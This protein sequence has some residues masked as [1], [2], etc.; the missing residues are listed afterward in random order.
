MK[1]LQNLRTKN[2]FTVLMITL[3]FYGLINTPSLRIF[4]Q[5]PGVIVRIYSDTTWM[6]SDGPYVLTGPLLVE[7]GVTLTVEAGSSID[8]NY[9]EMR[10]DGTLL[11]KGSSNNPVSIFNGTINYSEL[12]SGWNQNTNH[13]CIIENAVYDGV[14]VNSAV[15]LSIKNSK[16]NREVSIVGQ[17]LIWGNDLS[18]ISITGSSI[19][20][21]NNEIGAIFL[22]DCSL[23]VFENTINILEVNGDCFEIFDNTINTRLQGSV[24]SVQIYDNN[25][26]AIGYYKR[27]LSGTTATHFHADSATVTQNQIEGGL[28]LSGNSLTVTNNEI[29][30]YTDFYEWI[31]LWGYE[32]TYYQT[33][34]IILEGGGYVSGNLIVDCSIGVQGATIVEGNQILNTR[35]G[36]GGGPKDVIIRNNTI[37][38]SDS[39]ANVG[40]SVN[41]DGT[42]IVENNSIENGFFTGVTINSKAIIRSNTISNNSLGIGFYAKESAT[43]ERNLMENNEV[44]F[45]V[46]SSH[47]TIKNNTITNSGTAFLLEN[48]SEIS[49]N[50]N[51]IQNSSQH[52]I[53]LEKIS[54]DIDATN[55][56]WGTT[57][58]ET[59]NLAINDSKYSF[60][61]GTVNT[62]PFLTEQNTQ[63]KPEAN[64]QDL[65]SNIPEF[66]STIIFSSMF[67]AIFAVFV[68]RKILWR[69]N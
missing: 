32:K 31:L 19:Q 3:F 34:G 65:P 52:S 18:W 36:V 39:G 22:H 7:E 2:L 48:V 17:S 56:W 24:N 60:D 40:I 20:I 26:G 42:T 54:V 62:T 4:A 37:T 57:D 1:L 11:V 8:L 29:T 10:V 53:Y 6:M 38:A 27:G 15:A 55:N 5:A 28:C 63:A 30:G 25:I 45:R 43:I 16:I 68:A 13:G 50:Y 67:L 21:T 49:I 61:L 58:L 46:L 59:I 35:N 47:L 14:K 12:S 69:R 41:S 44:G 64:P 33:P 9:Y 51:N 23:N 66:T